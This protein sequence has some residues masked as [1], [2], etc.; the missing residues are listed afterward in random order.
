MSF[1]QL[2]LPLPACLPASLSVSLSVCLCH[3]LCL[4]YLSLSL[5]FCLSVCLSFCLSLTLSLSSGFFSLFLFFLLFSLYTCFS[6]NTLLFIITHLQWE[7]GSHADYILQILLLLVI[8][9]GMAAA[10]TAVLCEIRLCDPYNAVLVPH[11]TR[12][13]VYHPPPQPPP[14]FSWV[15]CSCQLDAFKWANH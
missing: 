14:L 2:F 8:L 9:M 3:C 13:P 7:F 4:F 1:M 10:G 15:G 6:W 5:C 12:T 11:F